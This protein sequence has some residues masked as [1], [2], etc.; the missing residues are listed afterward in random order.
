MSRVVARCLAMRAIRIV[1]IGPQSDAEAPRRKA[2]SNSQPALYR[3]PPGIGRDTRSYLARSRS[4][5]LG[6]PTV[7]ELAGMTEPTPIVLIPGLLGSP[8]LYG[9]RFRICGAG[10]LDH[11]GS[12]AR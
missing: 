3:H 4:A 11:R 7:T 5:R 6:R 8:R 2:L 9:T 12:H 1:G 10:T